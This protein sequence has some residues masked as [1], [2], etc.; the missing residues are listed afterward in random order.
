MSHGLLAGLPVIISGAGRGMGYTTAGASQL[1]RE[2]PVQRAQ[3]LVC[4]SVKSI[5]VTQRL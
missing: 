4:A 5:Q 2:P 1:A 3:R